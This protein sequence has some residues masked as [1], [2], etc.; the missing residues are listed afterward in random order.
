MVN[1]PQS[2]AFSTIWM[3][4]DFDDQ[5]T[6][7]RN[8]SVFPTIPNRST[9]LTCRGTQST[10]ISQLAGVFKGHINW[11]NPAWLGPTIN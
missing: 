3:G 5:V 11:V 1:Q 10:A 6:I 4:Q 2:P 8:A 9:L 7:G